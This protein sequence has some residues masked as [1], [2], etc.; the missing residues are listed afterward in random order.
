MMKESR[1]E[2]GG[3]QVLI[4]NLISSQG[5]DIGHKLHPPAL[6]PFLHRA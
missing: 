5:R 2:V 4:G 1:D 6:L 3:S